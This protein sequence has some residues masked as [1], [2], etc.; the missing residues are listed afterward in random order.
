MWHHHGGCHTHLNEKATL[1]EKWASFQGTATPIFI[2]D[3]IYDFSGL[4][5]EVHTLHLPSSTSF[6]MVSRQ[7]LKC[8]KTAVLLGKSQEN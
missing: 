6:D 7:I 2:S 1:T 5:K 8:E 4:S 3:S